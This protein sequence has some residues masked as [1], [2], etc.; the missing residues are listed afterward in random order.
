MIERVISG[1]QIG[2]DIAG[3]R[4]AK[5]LG[6]ETGGYMPLG[7]KAK[8]GAHP[9]YYTEF[10]MIEAPGDYAYR[11]ALNVLRSDGTIRFATNWKSYGEQATLREIEHYKKPYLDVD[12]SK[13]SENSALYEVHV[14]ESWII[15]ANIKVLNVAG[16]GRKDIEEFVTMFMTNLLHRV[17]KL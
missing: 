3:L 14:A 6:I 11:T 9:E 15:A 5:A 12:P 16:N 17:N 13:L 7:W 2:A 8:D 10:G 4:A 1:G